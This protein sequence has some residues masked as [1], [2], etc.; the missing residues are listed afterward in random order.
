M[1]ITKIDREEK[2][3]KDGL[4]VKGMYRVQIQESDGQIVGDS[5]WHRNVVTDLG[6]NLYLVKA[7]GSL[8]GS[9]YVSQMAL[10][11]GAAPATN[12]TTLAGEVSKRAA[13]TAATSATSKTLRLTATFNSSD[14]FVT[15]TKNIANIGLFNSTA[16]GSIFAGNTFASSS[17]ATNQSVNCTYD[18]TFA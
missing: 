12:D 18:V 14:S 1:A 4:K 15:A 13:V 16:A 3:M 7:L 5:G 8:A 6:F 9:L 2:K 17:C 11:T 10:G